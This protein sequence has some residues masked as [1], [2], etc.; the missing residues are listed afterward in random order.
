MNKKIYGIIVLVIIAVLIIIFSSRGTGTSDVTPTPTPENK[1]VGV[2]ERCGGNM[3]T[4]PR[5]D[6]SSHCAP[7][8]GSRLPFGDVGGV[9]VKN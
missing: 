9:C 1:V 7:E 4:A 5:C 8:P 2:G 6:A 3:T